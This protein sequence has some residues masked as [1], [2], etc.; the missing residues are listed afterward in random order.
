MAD[1]RTAQKGKRGGRICAAPIIIAYTTQQYLCSGSQKINNDPNNGLLIQEE[2]T[3][4]SIVQ[5]SYIMAT[6]FVQT[7]LRTVSS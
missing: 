6:P 5:S 1:K 4:R 3:W 2:Q 7:I